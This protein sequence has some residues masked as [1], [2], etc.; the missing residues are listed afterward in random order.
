VGEIG[1]EVID[2]PI[3]GFRCGTVSPILYRENT[4]AGALWA[5]LAAMSV[6]LHG[7]TVV[8]GTEEGVALFP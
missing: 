3:V 5:G 7:E 4:H 8:F 1:S 6:V 2:H